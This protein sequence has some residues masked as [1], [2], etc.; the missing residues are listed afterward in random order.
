MEN[1]EEFL[2]LGLSENTIKS[3]EEKGFERPTEIQSLTIPLLLREGTEVIAQAE[4]GSGKTAAFSLPV[5]ETLSKS[6]NTEALILCPTRELAIQVN[7]EF[8]SLKGKKDLVTLP[9]YGGASIENQIR[10][11]KKGVN[12]VIGTPGRVL[13]HIKR[14][15]LILDKIKFFILDEADQMLD[16]GFI[17]DIKEIFSHTRAARTLLFSATIPEDILSIAKEFLHEYEIIRTEKKAK[18]NINAKQ[19]YYV[20]SREDKIE[21]LKRIADMN[22]DFYAVVFVRTKA[23][24]D[25]I[26]ENL[27][28][29]GYRAS[30]LNGDLT[31]REREIVL[32]RMRERSIDILVA[33]D[34]AARGL[35]ING[36]TH[37]INYSL[38]EEA[39]TFIHRVGR[40]G[41]AGK[42]G[43]AI[44]L[45][46]R[47]EK[48]RFE[49]IL[50]V[51]KSNA[52]EDSIPS[53]EQIMA[54]KRDELVRKAREIIKKD[55][56]DEYKKLALAL[57]D[58][59]DNPLDAVSSLLEAMFKAEF[60][61][62][63]YRKIREEKEEDRR[64]DKRKE[65][66]VESKSIRIF[67]SRGRKAGLTKKALASLISDGAEIEY[68]SIDDVQVLDDF[69]FVNVR[70][71]DAESV[72]ALFNRGKKKGPKIATLAKKDKKGSEIKGRK[73]KGADGRRKGKKSNASK[74]RPSF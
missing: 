31:Q 40:T 29:Q 63:R 38:P 64:K 42:S 2:S 21:V 37:V 15:T 18:A 32:K 22:P 48:R 43:E 55:A 34:V 13:D 3:L 35:D 27:V 11:L 26:A 7:A 47:G 57:F 9:L 5:I 45:I 59:V 74:S 52:E 68:S 46:T 10:L 69:S 12:V 24:S 19:R 44:T 51:T 54:A 23:E 60:D 14:G 17:D 30:S 53:L 39:E 65:N 67:I 61:P 72:L 66:D 16:M 71:E 70:K 20:V 73:A 28:K 33:T 62:S 1:R 8:N 41:R 56:G 58:H 50:R 49:Y 36:L 6:R 25:E 4:T